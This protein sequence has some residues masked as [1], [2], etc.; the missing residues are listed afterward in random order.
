MFSVTEPVKRREHPVHVAS[1]TSHR[2]G[3]P[4]PICMHADL[5]QTSFS[6]LFIPKSLTA[7]D[8]LGEFP[9]VLGATQTDSAGAG[10]LYPN[11]EYNVT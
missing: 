10:C 5:S 11:L 1:L 6:L 4:N 8:G 9:N 7:I 2:S 3:T